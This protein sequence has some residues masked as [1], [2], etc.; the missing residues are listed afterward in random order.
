MNISLDIKDYHVDIPFSKPIEAEIPK[1]YS[2]GFDTNRFKELA[3]QKLIDEFVSKQKY[4]KIY[5]S[6]TDLLG[7]IRQNYYSRLKYKV[8]IE[9]YF[10]F[11]YLQLYADVGISIHNY[12][13]NIYD[14]SET[15]RDIISEKYKVKG[16][17][18]GIKTRFL[19]EI[20]GI[21][22]KDFNG[23]YKE[24]HF[25]QANIYAYLLNTE[26]SYNISTITLIYVFRDNLRAGPIP[27]DI[28][29]NDELALEYLKR[30]LILDEALREK[31]LPEKIGSSKET[32]R[33]CMYK[34][35]CKENENNT[36][37]E[38]KEKIL[39]KNNE[40]SKFSL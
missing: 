23:T 11:P 31:K 36:K 1:I 3:R 30:S 12:I 35:Y 28:P 37:K 29:V 5:T 18:D 40:T 4:E 19:Y 13:Q 10:N 27:I 39:S 8:K 22:S 32:C 15:E 14:F 20:K 25:I 7:C 21:D 24:T 2:V 6:V 16:R 9:N 33:F 17:A 34:E 38:V 26:A